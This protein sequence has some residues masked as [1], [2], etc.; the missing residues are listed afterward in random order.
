MNGEDVREIVERRTTLVDF[1][2]GLGLAGTHVGC[3]QGQPLGSFTASGL[4]N[5]ISGPASRTFAY[6]GLDRVFAC[7]MLQVFAT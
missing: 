3:E 4:G 5:A 1:L 6:D 2:R 7:A